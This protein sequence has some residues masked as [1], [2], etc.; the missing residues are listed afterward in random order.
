[1]GERERDREKAGGGRERGEREEESARACTC[2]RSHLAKLLD[3]AFVVAQLH[4]LLCQGQELAGVVPRQGHLVVQPCRDDVLYAGHAHL[5]GT[6]LL[7]V[8]PAALVGAGA[9]WGDLLLLLLLLW[10][11]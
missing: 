9:M 6:A 8:L 10:G 11:S 2:V 3:D 1:M 5:H 7:L 4:A